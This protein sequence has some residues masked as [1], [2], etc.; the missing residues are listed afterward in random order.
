[1]SLRDS[2]LKA[3][4]VD[5]RD[6]RRVNQEQQAERKGQKAERESREAVEARREAAAKAERE[7][8][9]AAIIA[10]R[11]ERDQAAELELRRR[12][13]G[14]LLRDYQLR[15]RGGTQPFWH[16]AADGLHTHKL[17][18][19][20]RMA[21][22]LWAGRLAIVWVGEPDDPDYLLL[23]AE[24]VPRVLELEPG[25]VLF[26]TPGGAPKDDPAERLHE[27]TDRRA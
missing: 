25:R 11:R 6:V 23:P 10:S 26:F 3:G 14:H 12:R 24:V 18:L 9:Q 2:L 21:W 1:M 15:H 20:E 4:V 13:V 7:A 16:R 22:E 19:S 17:Y 5:K 8:K 27:A